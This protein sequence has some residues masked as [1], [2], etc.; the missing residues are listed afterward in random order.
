MKRSRVVVLGMVLAAGCRLDEAGTT[1]FPPFSDAGAIVRD[2]RPPPPDAGSTMGVVDAA[3]P[4]VAPPVVAPPVEGPP[5]DAGPPPPP[6]AAPGAVPC[7][8]SA[9]LVFCARFEGAAIDESPSRLRLQGDPVRYVAGPTGL[10]AELEP[11]R[12]FT[13]A[14]TPILDSTTITLQA[15]VRPSSVDAAMTVVE[16]PGQYGIVILPS[17]DVICGAGS[18]GRVFAAGAVEPGVW[19]ELH[20]VIEDETITL[21]VDGE[22]TAVATTLPPATNRNF[23]LRIGW[24]DDPLR[25]FSGLIDEIRVWRVAHRPDAR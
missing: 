20:C 5:P 19:T 17:G 16:N 18:G 1:L 23:G 13:I 4:D 8:D 9:D 2:G 15:S 7:P 22:P 14:E 12:H 21:W 25:P 11:G 6:D 10:A 3:S 24:D